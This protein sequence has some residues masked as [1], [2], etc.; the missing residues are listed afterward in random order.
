MHDL[1]ENT[2]KL[3]QKPTAEIQNII[4]INWWTRFKNIEFSMAFYTVDTF[5]HSVFQTV[6]KPKNS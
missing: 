5:T 6:F 1:N 3:T 4:V 2:S